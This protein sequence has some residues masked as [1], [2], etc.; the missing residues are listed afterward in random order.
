MMR[1]GVWTENLS[2]PA[3]INECLMQSYDGVIRLFPNRT[4]LGAA[5]FR[6][7]R[8]AG[9]FLV[10]AAYDGRRVT[11]ATVRSEKGGRVRLVSPWRQSRVHT[12]RGNARV[13]F[14]E[15][16]VVL[17]LATTAGETYVFAAAG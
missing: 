3:V 13:T 11:S 10:S 15:K 2:L 4:N 14:T 12:A 5:A 17:E 9:A 1:M 16:E 8:A 6:D 7:L